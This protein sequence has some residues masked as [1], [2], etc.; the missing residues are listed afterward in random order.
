[1]DRRFF[2]GSSSGITP[3]VEQ[4][5]KQRYIS[6]GQW[7]HDFLDIDFTQWMFDIAVLGGAAEKERAEAIRAESIKRLKARGR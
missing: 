4:L 1:V 6:T 2:S 5:L 3:E 7:P